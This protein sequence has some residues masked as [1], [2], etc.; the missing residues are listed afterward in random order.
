V[1]AMPLHLRDV[2]F[3]GHIDPA[4]PLGGVAG[5]GWLALAC[6]LMVLCTCGAVLWWRYRWVER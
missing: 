4:S 2:I 6:Y 3:L 1:L 5:A